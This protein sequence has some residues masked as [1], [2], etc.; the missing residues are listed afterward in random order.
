MTLVILLG[1]IDIAVGSVEALAGSVAAVLMVIYK[2]PTSVGIL[3]AI[4]ARFAFIG[5]LPGLYCGGQVRIPSMIVPSW[6]L[7]APSGPGLDPDEWNGRV[8]SATFLPVHWTGQGG[9]HSP[10]PVILALVLFF[11]TFAI[12]R[13]C[14]RFGTNIYAT[15]SNEEAA[16]LSG[17]NLAS[18]RGGDDD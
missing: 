2:M 13:F 6:A 5:A 3:G 4:V 9:H 18:A 1:E 17:I 14:T 10:S 15:G 16:R 11:V 8:R 12:L 7:A